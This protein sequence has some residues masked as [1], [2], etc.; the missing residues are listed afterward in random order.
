MYVWLQLQFKT[1]CKQQT[2]EKLFVAIS[3]EVAEEI[4]CHI[5]VLLEMSVRGLTSNKSIHYLLDYGDL[6]CQSIMN[7][8]IELLASVPVMVEN[9]NLS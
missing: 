4:F 8:L 3:F 7:V 5:F 6:C 9:R 2:F 1:D